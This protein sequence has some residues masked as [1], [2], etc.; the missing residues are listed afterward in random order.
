MKYT[1]TDINNVWLSIL[2]AEGDEFK[3]FL[4]AE[5]FMK[6]DPRYNETHLAQLKLLVEEKAIERRLSDPAWRKDSSV[7]KGWKLRPASDSKSKSEKE[8]LLSK[9]GRQFPG[10]R[11]ALKAM[12]EEGWDSVQVEEMRNKLPHEGWREKEGL[13]RNW[14]VKKGSDRAAQ[15]V[16]ETGEKLESTKRAVLWL[17]NK[18]R[19]AEVCTLLLM[20]DGRILFCKSHKYFA[21]NALKFRLNWCWHSRRSE[22]IKVSDRCLCACLMSERLTRSYIDIY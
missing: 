6:A 1:F 12:V 3:S 5:E 16:T 9:D 13:P 22:C 15:F 2:N 19:E 8:F 11:V 20:F 10:R 21:S 4:K 18:D 7:P 17:R 14:F